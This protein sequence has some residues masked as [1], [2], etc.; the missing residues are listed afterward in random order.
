RREPVSCTRRPTGGIHGDAPPLPLSHGWRRA[1][2][3]LLLV[4]VFVAIPLIFNDFW[5]G[6]ITTGVAL[7]IIFLSYTLV[8]GEGGMISLAQI[9]FA[10]IG[11][12]VAARLATEASFPIGIAIVCV[13]LVELSFGLGLLF[14][15]VR[16]GY[17][18]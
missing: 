14:V 10:G 1:A 16:T 4:A 5:L 13:A 6:V 8:T 9:S 15:S 7:S 3:P 12:F 11:G 2:G 18:Y 17:P